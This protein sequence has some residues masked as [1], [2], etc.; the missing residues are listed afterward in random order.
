MVMC[1]DS[2]GN[3]DKNMLG[4]PWLRK[5]CYFDESLPLDVKIF[6]PYN[7]VLLLLVYSSI[8]DECNNLRHELCFWDVAVE[9][10]IAVGENVLQIV[11]LLTFWKM[12][13]MKVGEGR[14]A[15]LTDHEKMVLNDP[16]VTTINDDRFWFSIADSA[17]F[18]WI[19]GLAL[20]HG[21][22]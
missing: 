5:A 13:N 15:I 19:K 9:P 7:R 18:Y 3:V 12:S 14:Y 17:M 4:G 16:V 8:E 21:Q 10:Q 6:V 20:G 11:M 2:H 22:K 1:P